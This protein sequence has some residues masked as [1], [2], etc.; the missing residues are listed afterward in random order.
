MTATFS[1][2]LTIALATW[3]G[4]I[5]LQ[6]LVV[7]PT[8]FTVLDEG[9]AGRV[10]RRL[11]PRFFRLGLICGAVALL[12]I[13][14]LY[15]GPVDAPHAGIATLVLVGAITAS[16]G[17]CLWLVPRIN[18]ARD[19]GPSGARSFRQLHGASVTLT[20]AALAGAGTVLGQIAAAAV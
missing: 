8:L 20:L 15:L 3:L 5:V 19:R 18:A 11:F 16:Q 6:S 4:A 17:I 2:V 14:A 7:A 13:A 10:L 1:I 12:C 9:P